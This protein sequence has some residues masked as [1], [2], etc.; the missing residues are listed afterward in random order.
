MPDY[1]PYTGDVFTHFIEAMKMGM[2][3]KKDEE[4]KKVQAITTGYAK[5]N[6]DR[7]RRLES[8]NLTYGSNNQIRSGAEYDQAIQAISQPTPRMLDEIFLGDNPIPSP[9]S[10]FDVKKYGSQIPAKDLNTF[11]N[12]PMDVVASLGY[13]TPME[14]SEQDTQKFINNGV[15]PKTLARYI[16]GLKNLGRPSNLGVITDPTTGMQYIP[17]PSMKAK[18]TIVGTPVNPQ[19]VDVPGSNQQFVSYNVGQGR[20]GLLQV[21]PTEKTLVNTVSGKSITVPKNTEM[22]TPP[23]A[24]T[25]M[26][27]TTRLNSLEQGVTRLER[28]LAKVPSGRLGGNFASL[29]NFMGGWFPEAGNAKDLGGILAPMTTR[30]IGGDVGNLSI[31]EQ[32]AAKNMTASLVSATKEE[33]KL[34]FDTIRHLIS[35]RR[36]ANEQK[37]SGNSLI[38]GDDLSTVLKDNTQY[39]KF[40][41]AA[42]SGD[43]KEANTFAPVNKPTNE[44]D[45]W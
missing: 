16:E 27:T 23:G 2:S 33:R 8:Q 40:I 18:P 5:E 14:A 32:I 3:L 25:M 7:A 24:S 39:Q 37:L 44:V 31:T 41:N 29:A 1:T 45:M 43:F 34:A 28:T 36:I 35:Y 11:E 12:I 15:D 38:W 26:E 19:T 22:W 10:T 13:A 20:A 21:Q 42:A 9:A 30:L 4:A 17:G 6:T